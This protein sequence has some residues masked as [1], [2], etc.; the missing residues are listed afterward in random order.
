MKQQLK[1]CHA[2]WPA[3]EEEQKE[4]IKNI[5]KVFDPNYRPYL[6]VFRLGQDRSLTDTIFRVVFDVNNR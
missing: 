5:Q 6:R 2:L 1:L 3:T 4:R